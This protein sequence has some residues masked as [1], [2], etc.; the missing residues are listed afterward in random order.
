[1]SIVLIVVYCTV[2]TTKFSTFSQIVS[3]TPYSARKFPVDFKT[4]LENWIWPIF[5]P[6]RASF[7]TS[8]LTK[9][10]VLWQFFFLITLVIFNLSTSGVNMLYLEVKYN[11]ILIFSR[12]F[13][14]LLYFWEFWKLLFYPSFKK[15][16][17][18]GAMEH[19]LY[20][21]LIAIVLTQLSHFT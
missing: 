11:Q 9:K 3:V 16:P 14:I 19:N 2:D 6:G 8:C 21:M 12:K 7:V 10:C 4:V 18:D 15:Q 20:W 1:M 17:L 13:R 5:D